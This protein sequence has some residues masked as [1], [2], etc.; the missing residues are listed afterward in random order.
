MTEDQALVQQPQQQPDMA[1]AGPGS[2]PGPGPGPGGPP[3]VGLHPVHLVMPFPREFNRTQALLF[4]FLMPVGM[5][6]MIPHFFLMLVFGL[7]M[8]FINLLSFFVILFTGRY[9]AGWW[10]FMRKVVRY[11]IRIATYTNVLSVGYPSFSL[12]D[13][14]YPVDIQM[15]YPERSSRFWLFFAG[16]AIIPVA[17]VNAVLNIAASVLSFLGSF[18]ILFTGSMPV[19]WFEFI[20]KVW[21]QRV[22]MLCFQYWLRNEYPPFGLDD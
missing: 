1:G 2:G 12:A 19:G 20:R 14:T 7:C 15:P 8:G 5:I 18:A 3:N 4:T 16:I 17:I 13:D 6:L 11:A 21:Q 10:E 9:P 22:R